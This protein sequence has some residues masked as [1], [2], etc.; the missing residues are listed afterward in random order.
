MLV[1]SL[2]RPWLSRRIGT[3]TH[4]PAPSPRS[5][6][7]RAGQVAQNA[8]VVLA[9]I[10]DANDPDAQA[11]ATLQQS[12]LPEQAQV[13]AL[14]LPSVSESATDIR[15]RVTRGE[16]VSSLVP[17]A[18]AGYIASHHLYQGHH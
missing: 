7:R 16:D 11:H 10:P 12:G 18:V 14:R 3:P 5:R 8:C 1:L 2:L 6:E 15:G 4:K 9:E 17:P 13:R